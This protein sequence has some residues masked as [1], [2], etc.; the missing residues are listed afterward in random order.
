MKII[1]FDNEKI[2]DTLQL[3]N[4]VFVPIKFGGVCSGMFALKQIELN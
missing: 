2:K 4:G 1:A 3:P